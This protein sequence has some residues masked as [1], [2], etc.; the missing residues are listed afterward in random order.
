MYKLYYLV[1]QDGDIDGEKQMVL[2]TD[3]ATKCFD[4]AN[5]DKILHYSIEIESNGCATIYFVC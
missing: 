4:R 5:K 3:S 2:K 1:N